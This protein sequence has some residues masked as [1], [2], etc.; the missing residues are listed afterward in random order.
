[1]LVLNRKH[2]EEI[3]IGSDVRI[4]VL[5]VH[6]NRVKLGISAPEKVFIRR[7]ELDRKHTRQSVPL[8][9]VC[10]DAPLSQPALADVSAQ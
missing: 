7:G 9:G 10:A 6:G 5:A 8:T 1:M 4:T 3:V 2:G